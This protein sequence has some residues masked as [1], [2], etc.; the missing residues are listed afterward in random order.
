MEVFKSL[1]E[2]IQQELSLEMKSSN[3]GGSGGS[4]YVDASINTGPIVERYCHTNLAS[5]AKLTGTKRSA[6]GGAA[7][8]DLHAKTKKT[9]M[10]ANNNYNNNNNTI[11]NKHKLNNIPTSSASRKGCIGVGGTSG[12][13][14]AAFQY[15]QQQ[16]QHHQRKESFQGET[17]NVAESGE[18]KGSN[19]NSSSTGLSSVASSINIDEVDLEFLDALPE[20]LRN[21]QLDFLKSLSK[22]KK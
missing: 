12:S 10:A 21:E 11:N 6:T 22:A 2:H 19:S 16:H 3:V 15:Q 7:A 13:I 20:D 8:S 5:Q 14:A 9:I 4:S 18:G 17:V 1:P